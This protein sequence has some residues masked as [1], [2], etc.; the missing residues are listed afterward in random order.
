MQI[1]H[2][3]PVD[4]KKTS[5]EPRTELCTPIS[6]H[7]VGEQ[8]SDSEMMI[9]VIESRDPQNIVIRQGSG[10]RRILLT[11]PYTKRIHAG[12]SFVVSRVHSTL[13][14]QSTSLPTRI[15]TEEGKN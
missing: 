8:T 6:K 2:T 14:S 9:R 15:N 5:F 7:F 11:Y 12:T 10:E 13:Y 4:E 3:Q 1:E